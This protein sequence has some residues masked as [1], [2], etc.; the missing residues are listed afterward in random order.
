[1]ADPSLV[2]VAGLHA[3]VYCERLF[4]L[5]EAEQFGSPTSASMRAGD[6]TSRSWSGRAKRMASVSDSS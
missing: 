4:Y 6:F 2:S 1:M 3:L 5:E